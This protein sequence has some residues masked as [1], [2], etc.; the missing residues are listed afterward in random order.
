MFALVLDLLGVRK[1]RPKRISI[2]AITLTIE[3]KAYE[4]T[5]WSMSGFRLESFKRPVSVGETLKGQIG[6]LGYSSGGGFS[7]SVVRLTEAGGFGACWSDIE[8]DIY[9]AMSG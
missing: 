5:N 8:R 2:P 3:G 4:T 7:A 6:E 1:R 9:T